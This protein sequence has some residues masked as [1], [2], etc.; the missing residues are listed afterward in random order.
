MPCPRK[1]HI[2]MRALWFSATSTV[3]SFWYL[4]LEGYI[5]CSSWLLPEWDTVNLHQFDLLECQKKAQS[6]VSCTFSRIHHAKWR[7]VPNYDLDFVHDHVQGALH[8][9]NITGDIKLLILHQR[10]CIRRVP[11][12]STPLILARPST[13]WVG[14]ESMISYYI[15]SYLHTFKLLY[16]SLLTSTL[17][18]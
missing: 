4:V 18:Y 12:I 3:Q 11:K 13:D 7:N 17:S 16:F 8:V 2:H 15:L 6:E 14:D 9:K 5:Y 10:S 1:V